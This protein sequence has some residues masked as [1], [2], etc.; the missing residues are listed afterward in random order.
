LAVDRPARLREP[1]CAT[2]KGAMLRKAERE[3]RVQTER[4]PPG[5]IFKKSWSAVFSE[6]RTTRACTRSNSVVPVGQVTGARNGSRNS[7]SSWKRNRP[8]LQFTN[9]WCTLA[10]L[11]SLLVSRW[12]STPLTKVPEKV[13]L[14]C[15]VAVVAV[16]R[17]CKQQYQSDANGEV[18]SLH[19]SF[20]KAT[21]PEDNGAVLLQTVLRDPDRIVGRACEPHVSTAVA[22]RTL[23][24]SPGS[25]RGTAPHVSTLPHGIESRHRIH[26]VL[27]AK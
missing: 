25:R 12:F 3:V 7:N 15:L 26:E 11:P 4:F 14:R 2:S 27:V 24:P 16:A 21:L 10:D 13:H 22:G 20:H 1:P 9:P 19:K 6:V 23:R 5:R 8:I 17:S 18:T